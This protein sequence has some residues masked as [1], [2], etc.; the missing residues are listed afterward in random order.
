MMEGSAARVL[1]RA[2]ERNQPGRMTAI[3]GNAWA[4]WRSFEDL[5]PD[6][7]TLGVDD[8][9][10]FIETYESSIGGVL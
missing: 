4:L 10:A 3:S 7:D 1:Q 9:P 6:D 8:M 5:T 2:M